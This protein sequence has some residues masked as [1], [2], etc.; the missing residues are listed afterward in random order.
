MSGWDVI[1][2][3]LDLWSAQRRKAEFWWRDDD[4]RDVSAQLKQMISVARA[5]EVSVGLSVIPVGLKRELNGFVR[6]TDCVDVLVH[7]YAHRNHA[8]KGAPKAEFAA[9]RPVSEMLDELSRGL[10]LL[11]SAFGP[12]LLAVAVPPWNRISGRVASHLA[13]SGFVGLSTWKPRPLSP[14]FKGVVQVNTHLDLID[15]RHGRVVKS[16]GQVIG[17]LL[18]K[19]RWRRQN[20]LRAKEPLGLLTHHALWCAQKEA[21][22]VQL[23]RETRHHPA[24]R[25]RSAREVFGL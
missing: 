10:A 22:V 16:E 19:L 20:P 12:R 24:V 1:E 4:A 7:G 18:R 2:R 15:W 25:W 3:E 21:I 8:A 13:A 9:D 14:G 23:L 5:H 17:L 6:A 11:Q